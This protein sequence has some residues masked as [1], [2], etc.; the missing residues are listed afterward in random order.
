MLTVISMPVNITSVSSY[1]YLDV[2]FPLTSS[3]VTVVPTSTYVMIRP[4]G[5]Y[6]P[7]TNQVWSAQGSSAYYNSGNVGIGTTSPAYTLDVVGN[8][9][10]SGSIL[11]GGA[12]LPASQWTTLNS[13]IYY[14]SNVSIGSSSNPGLNKLLV[15]G[16]IATSNNINF[17]QGALLSGQPS[18]VDWSIVNSGG[19]L[20][21]ARNSTTSFLSGG[22]LQLNQYG[23]VG[24][25]LTNPTALLHIGA[26][27]SNTTDMI[28]VQ[29]YA[30]T[31]LFKVQSTGGVGLGVATP[32]YQLDLSTDGARKLSSTAWITG[33]DSRIKSNVQV[34]NVHRCY[35]IV[36]AL[37]LKYFRWDFA[38][39][40]KVNDRHSLG[41]IAQEVRDIFPKAV[42]SSNSYGFSD[43]LSLDTD[44]ILKA[45]YGA[46]KKTMQDKEELEKRVLAL[47]TARSST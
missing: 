32:G 9:N 29:T 1:Y 10:F 2:T 40:V 12:P 20:N 26:N 11:Q 19:C 13:N 41:F 28:H 18:A 22:S 38:K 43:F 47:E 17:P 24:I 3:T 15:T 36:N 35:E 21:F 7:P 37:D 27:T 42:T 25:Q 33:S 39:D 46:L 44:Q 14:L 34:A 23:M 16:N 4:I 5:T 31:T 45:M 6:L 30:G 8:I